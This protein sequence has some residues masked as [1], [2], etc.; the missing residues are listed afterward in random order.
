MKFDIGEFLFQVALSIRLAV[1]LTYVKDSQD[2]E[3][4]YICTEPRLRGCHS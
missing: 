3:G 4:K 2:N 1:Y